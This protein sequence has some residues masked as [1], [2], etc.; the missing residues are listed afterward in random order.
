[1]TREPSLVTE[2]SSRTADA[3]TYSGVPAH[4]P[5]LRRELNLFDVIAVVVGTV[6]GSGIFLIPSYIAA[7]IHSFGVVV[8]V[9][10]V[11]GILTA[12]GALSLA[13]L[14]SM[15]PATGGLCIYLRHAYGPLV[16]FLYA[17]GLL[18]MIHSGSIAGL[19]VAFGLYA[20]HVAHLSSIDEKL[21][22]GA[23]VL[24]LTAIN[25]I[26]IRGG[27]LTQNLIA[28]TKVAGLAAIILLLCFRGSRPL[29]LF[30]SSAALF[31]GH[32]LVGFGIALVAVMWAY[33]GW[34]TV[35]FVAG[36]MKRP[37]VDLPRGLVF[38]VAL[39]TLIY[40]A[41][42]FGYYR[43]L[44]VAE[45]RGTDTL[46]A[47]AVEKLFGPAA[48]VLISAL[49][50]ISILGSMN[51]LVLTGPRAYFAMASEGEFPQ[52]F[53]RIS[54]RFR[55]PMIALIVQ[56][57]WATVLALSGSYQQLFTDVIFT[58]WIFYGLA[59]A[60]V[61]VLRIRHPR[62]ERKFR[63]PGYPW[64]SVLFCLAALGLVISTIAERP[65]GAAVGIALLASGIPVYLLSI[66]SWTRDAERADGGQP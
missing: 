47:F 60:A 66:K 44:S 37:Q 63:V 19:A 15:Y 21:L 6:I 48:G 39:V 3:G 35:S 65:S 52:T 50:V 57:I 4:S 40:L 12:F 9:W 18:L 34:H 17:W 36:E 56:G 22:S 10:V 26:G 30:E 51:G 46:A 7:Q 8:L 32:S 2:E 5:N 29:Q 58:A 45:I 20:G 24:V 27:K 49:I 28:V 54:D 1:V 11:G 53:G 31:S 55:T 16:A 33:E 14:G 13:E 59:V 23:C 61:V 42:N 64:V 41:A 25:C 38:G 43:L 62:L